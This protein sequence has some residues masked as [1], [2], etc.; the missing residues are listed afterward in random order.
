MK[1]VHVVLGIAAVAGAVWYLKNKKPEEVKSS[2]PAFAPLQNFSEVKKTGPNV[3]PGTL[4]QPTSGNT[5]VVP[6]TLSLSQNSIPIQ[7]PVQKPKGTPAMLLKQDFDSTIFENSLLLRKT[8]AL[9]GTDAY[10]FV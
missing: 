6:P 9:R 2:A 10:L 4:L 7:T 8:T 5:G 1:T 3:L